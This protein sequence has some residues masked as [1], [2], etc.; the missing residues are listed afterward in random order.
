M[1]QHHYCRLFIEDGVG[2]DRGAT[3]RITA[4]VY[5]NFSHPF[6]PPHEDITCVGEYHE[7]HLSCD[8]E[9]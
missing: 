7:G 6:L 1:F 9:W 8:P 2:R 5:D 3:S 4:I